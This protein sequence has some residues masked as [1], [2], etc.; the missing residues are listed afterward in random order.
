[1]RKRKRGAY[2]SD[3][4]MTYALVVCGISIVCGYLPAGFGLSVWGCL[5]LGIA[6]IILL[7]RVVGKRVD[8]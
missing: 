1:M 7:L 3:L 8:V 2:R 5:I 6:A 4:Q